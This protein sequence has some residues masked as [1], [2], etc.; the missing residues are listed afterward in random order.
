MLDLRFVSLARQHDP[1]SY[2]RASFKV[3][4]GVMLDDLERELKHLDAKN[5]VIQAGFARHQIRNDGWPRGGAVAAHPE[6]VLSFESRHGPLSY[7]CSAFSTWEHNLR[8]IGL[9]LQR[10]RLAV[11]E[12]GIGVR[13]EVYRGFAALPA[14]EGPQDGMAAR[15]WLSQL[16]GLPAQT[17]TRALYRAAAK[18][19]HPDMQG[20]SADLMCRVNRAVQVIER[21]E[22]AR[23][24]AGAMESGP[25]AT[26]R[27]FTPEESNHAV[28]GIVRRL[29][30]EGDRL[31]REAGKGE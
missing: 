19:A 31:R 10:S 27:W 29:N 2:R 28:D 3:Q 15:R 26:A 14:A 4:H 7:S 11:E 5:I 20:G 24:E 1:T 17:E 21:D 6:I 23:R 8:A 12:W 9:H 22:G 16:T 25:D 13:G 18:V 30:E